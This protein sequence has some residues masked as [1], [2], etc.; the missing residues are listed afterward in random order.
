MDK[1][2]FNQIQTIAE[3]PNFPYSSFSELQV[4]IQ[5]NR[6]KIGAAMDKARGWAM[7]GMASKF[8]TY[9]LMSLGFLYFVLPIAVAIY[10]IIKGEY[11]NTLYAVV[12]LVSFLMLRPMSMRLGIFF[13]LIIWVGYG[14]I[15]INLFNFL[16]IWSLYLGLSIIIP[17]QINKLIYSIATNNAIS[18]SQENEMSFVTLFK[19]GIICIKQNDGSILWFDLLINK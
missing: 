18:K 11:L 3:I 12:A 2:T 5:E 10:F 14:L 1:A 13:R 9:L 6:I 4:N 19:Y 7:S 16:G 17:W 8:T 15:L